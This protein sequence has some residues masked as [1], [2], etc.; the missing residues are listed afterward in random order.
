VHRSLG[1]YQPALFVL[2]LL[3]EG[4]HDT[5]VAVARPSPAAVLANF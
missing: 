3:L 4:A 2:E 5:D 1:G